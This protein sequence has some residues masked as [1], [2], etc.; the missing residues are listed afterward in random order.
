MEILFDEEKRKAYQQR[1][2]VNKNLDRKEGIVSN[3]KFGKVD[4][5]GR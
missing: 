2:D 4:F 5:E 1:Y 3:M